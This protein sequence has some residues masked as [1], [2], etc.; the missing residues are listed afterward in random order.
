MASRLPADVSVAF[1]LGC[2]TA[3]TCYAHAFFCLLSYCKS[4]PRWLTGRMGDSIVSFNAV[5]TNGATATVGAVVD[6]FTEATFD[7]IITFYCYYH[8]QSTL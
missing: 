4:A 8:S 3:M 6:D 2:A 7:G 5:I 1:A